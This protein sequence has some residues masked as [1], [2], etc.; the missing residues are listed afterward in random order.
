M[1]RFGNKGRMKTAA[2]AGFPYCTITSHPTGPY[3]LA[4]NNN[5]PKMRTALPG[6][7]KRRKK[8]KRNSLRFLCDGRII[9]YKTAYDEGQACLL[10]I[11]SGG[12]AC[13]SASP[14]PSVQEKVLISITLEDEEDVVEAKAV[15]VR[16]VDNQFY[17]KFILIEPSTQNRIRTYFSWKARNQ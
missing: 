7:A 8:S 1:T 13:G 10:N 14:V 3:H 16:A 6:N 2:V 5:R 12:C 15:V 11:C 9:T 4:T 17:L